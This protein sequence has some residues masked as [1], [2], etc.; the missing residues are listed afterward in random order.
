M[1]KNLTIVARI[2]A[3]EDKVELVKSE[4]IKLIEPTRAE[5]GCIQYD[6]H[7]DKDNPAV[8][9]FYENWES[10]ILWQDHMKNDHLAAYAH[11]T[12]GAVVAFELNE[13]TI[14]SK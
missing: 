7:Q 8:F 4:L 2:Q 12:R 13:M 10:K 6:L 5:K 9:I 14:I 3:K 11:A 1:S